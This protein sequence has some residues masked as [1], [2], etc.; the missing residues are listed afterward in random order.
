V[1]NQPVKLM[2]KRPGPDRTVAGTVTAGRKARW[3]F[4]RPQGRRSGLY[5]LAPRRIVPE[6][7]RCARDRAPA[8]G[9]QP[10]A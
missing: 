6:L 5:V 2:S 8:H 9:G 1:R 10:H 3:D 7:G 4:K